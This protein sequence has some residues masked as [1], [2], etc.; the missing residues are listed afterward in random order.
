MVRLGGRLG[1]VSPKACAGYHCGPRA[2]KSAAALI[3]RPVVRPIRSR[4]EFD[5]ALTELDALVDADPKQGTAASD[6]MELPT[7]S[8]TPNGIHSLLGPLGAKWPRAQ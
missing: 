2:V 5:R 3:G 8:C 4:T 1:A 7:G 6:R